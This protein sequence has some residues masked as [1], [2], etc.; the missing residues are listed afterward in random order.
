MSVFCTK[1]FVKNALGHVTDTDDAL[2][3]SGTSC[4]GLVLF[5]DLVNVQLFSSCR[6]ALCMMPGMYGVRVLSTLGEIRQVGELS[7][8]SVVSMLSRS[9]EFVCLSY[10]KFIICDNSWSTEV[11]RDIRIAASRKTTIKYDL[12]KLLL[13]PDCRVYMYHVSPS[14]IRPKDINPR[15]RSG[16]IGSGLYMVPYIDSAKS[17]WG[18]YVNPRFGRCIS[19]VNIYSLKF[20]PKLY[21]GGRYINSI[22]GQCLVN[23]PEDIERMEF[24]DFVLKKEIDESV[25]NGVPAV[26]MLQGALKRECSFKEL[27]GLYES[28]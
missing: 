22:G 18:Y 21:G 1:E 13:T 20:L 12:T 9:N 5:Y 19:T 11:L 2:F 6:R 3:Y 10:I 28:V 7:G 4:S 27:G 17:M 26:T 8:I 15:H 16:E 24:V 14:I 25:S 23:L